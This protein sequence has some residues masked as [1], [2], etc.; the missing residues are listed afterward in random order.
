MSHG[1]RDAFGTPL[2]DPSAA[3]LSRP[4]PPPGGFAPEMIGTQNKVVV[5]YWKSKYEDAHEEVLLRQVQIQDLLDKG[6][7]LLSAGAKLAYH[8][9]RW[10]ELH[11]W[12]SASTICSDTK[13][14][15]ETWEVV[16]DGP[17]HRAG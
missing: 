6:R 11:H 8:L 4:T 3:P 1:P 13:E 7:W 16:A 12:K 2:G 15:L 14:A 5:D 9:N 17:Q 10:G